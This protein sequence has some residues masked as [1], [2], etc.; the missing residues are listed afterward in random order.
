MPIAWMRVRQP[1][2]AT[3]DCLSE[4]LHASRYVAYAWKDQASWYHVSWR[5]SLVTRPMPT[6]LVSPAPGDTT[7]ALDIEFT[8]HG[9]LQPSSA[10]RRRQVGSLGA[11]LLSEVQARC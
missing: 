5:D 3:D 4:A 11:E 7:A 10:A 6:A 2:T 8:W 9:N 1:M